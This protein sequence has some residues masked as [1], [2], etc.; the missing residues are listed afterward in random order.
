MSEILK[1]AQEFQQNSQQLTK[2]TAQ[3]V[4]DE[5]NQLEDFTK[6]RVAK[7]QNIITSAMRDHDNQIQESLNH[8][9][10]KL[11]TVFITGLISGLAIAILTL[12]AAS[13][14]GVF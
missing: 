6:K 2:R 5:L 10:L 7:S 3:I 4:N 9:Q 1:L 12:Y 14:L 13:K 8:I 11:V